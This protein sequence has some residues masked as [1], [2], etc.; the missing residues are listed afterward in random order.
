MGG[1]ASKQDKGKDNGKQ[2]RHKYLVVVRHGERLDETAEEVSADDH[3]DTQ[4]TPTGKAHSEKS[5]RGLARLLH[6][7]GL[8]AGQPKKVKFISSVF[9]R[10]LQTTACLRAGV[11][12]YVAE[13]Q[14]D[15]PKAVH[16]ALVERKTHMEDA[17]SEKIKQLPPKYTANLR[18]HRDLPGVLQEFAAIKPVYRSLFDYEDQHKELCVKRVFHKSQHIYETCFQAFRQLV[19]RLK[20]DADHD[21]YVVVAHGMYVQL[22]LMFLEREITRKVGYNHAV[23]ARLAFD[24][25]GVSHDLLVDNK[26]LF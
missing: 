14:F 4:L 19:K 25:S 12:Q 1:A 13:Q 21:V 10:C 5:G 18:V 16:H 9:Y 3:Y 8:L 11:A 22:F 24:D 6:E 23:V 17:Y 2:V 26:T 15:D 20:H 7:Q